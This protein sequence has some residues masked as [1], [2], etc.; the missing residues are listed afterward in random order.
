M[1]RE[2]NASEHGIG[3]Q[4]Q[5]DRMNKWGEEDFKAKRLPEFALFLFSVKIN[6]TQIIVHK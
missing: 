2:S 5:F 4:E 1:C 6:L 3:L